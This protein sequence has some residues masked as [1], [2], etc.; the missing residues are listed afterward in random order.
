MAEP[1]RAVFAP[2][3]QD[4][5]W[6]DGRGWHTPD[7]VAVLCPACRAVDRIPRARLGLPAVC[8]SC[9]HAY[10]APEPPGREALGRRRLRLVTIGCL[11]LAA[12]ILIWRFLL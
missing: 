7:L 5:A 1:R 11:A 4:R 3:A 2:V 8:E 6:S 12:L 10:L 9:G